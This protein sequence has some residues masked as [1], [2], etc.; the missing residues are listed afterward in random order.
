MSRALLVGILVASLAAL[1]ACVQ[2]P[3][4]D[5]AQSDQKLNPAMN[6]SPA[7]TPAETG[8]VDADSPK[9]GLN[10]SRPDSIEDLPPESQ[11]ATP[12]PR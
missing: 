11:R 7:R 8:D 9:S 1:G 2:K 3:V 12:A 4:S 10:T 5:S 6:A